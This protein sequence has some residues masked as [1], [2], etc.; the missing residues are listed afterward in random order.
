VPQNY[1]A[2]APWHA[3]WD[4]AR[5]LLNRVTGGDFP[6]TLALRMSALPNRT[7]HGDVLFENLELMRTVEVAGGRIERRPDLF[8]LRR[9]PTARHFAGQRVRQAYDELARPVRLAAWLTVVPL[10][11]AARRR[12]RLLIAIASSAVA[13]AELGRRRAG[14]QPHFHWT[15]SVC[16]PLWVLERSVCSWIA[17]AMRLRGGVRYGGDRLTIAAHSRRTIR[18]RLAGALA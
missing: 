13:V 12:R 7:Y 10:V 6:G 16:A 18:R 1:F 17:V 4:S 3:R 8:V 15:C 11:I 5:S 2:P 9:P 14:A